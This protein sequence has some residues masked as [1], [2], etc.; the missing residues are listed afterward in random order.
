MV[1]KKCI[2]NLSSYSSKSYISV[3]L[4]DS[5][6]T[7]LG[8]GD[9]AA[10]YPFLYRLHYIIKEVCHQIF[11]SSIFHKIFCQ[12]M[13]LFLN[14]FFHQYIKFFLHKLSLFEVKL[15]IIN[16]CDSNFKS[17]SKEILDIFFL[18]H[19][20]F[21]L[22]VCSLL[23]TSFTACHVHHDCLSSY[24]FLILLIYP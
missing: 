19:K 12:G 15:G 11:L 20:N 17:T 10:F 5:K 24:E 4:S 9:D 22:E 6:L 13:Q 3:V 16:Y 18:F 2:I 23:P 1:E 8:K 21:V 14:L 7:F